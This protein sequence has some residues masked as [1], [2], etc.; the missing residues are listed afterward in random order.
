ML[1]YATER[2]S[3]REMTPEDA[4]ALL[5]IWGDPETMRF[6]PSPK[7]ATEMSGWVQ[8]M[9]QRYRDDGIG[10]WIIESHEGDF[11]GDC[12]LT[13]QSVNGRT[14]LEVGYHVHPARQRSGL[15]AEAAA[16]CVELARRRFAPITITAII[17][18]DNAASRRVAEKLGMTHT[19]DDIAHPWITRTVMSMRLHSAA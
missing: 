4:P 1:P 17:H 6:Y 7:S 18:P 11:I 9:V 5:Q 12:G 10:L 15:A 16:A 14:V 19:E 8:R 3:F 13:W 2:L